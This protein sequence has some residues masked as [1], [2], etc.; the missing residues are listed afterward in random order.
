VTKEQ[1]IQDILRSNRLQIEAGERV[2]KRLHEN[3]R[4]LLTALKM[5]VEGLDFA[6]AQ[7]ESQSDHKKLMSYWSLVKHAVTKAE[8]TVK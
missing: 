7:T 1:E 5:A 2:I 8:G 3:Q 6:Q 4:D